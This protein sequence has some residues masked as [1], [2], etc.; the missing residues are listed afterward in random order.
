MMQEVE[1]SRFNLRLQIFI[2]QEVEYSR[3]NNRLQNL[4]CQEVEYSRFNLRLQNL[5][6]QE[7]EYSRFSFRL[8]NLICQEVEYSWF[9]LLL[10]ILICQEA[11]SIENTCTQQSCVSC[12][13]ALE[14]GAERCDMLPKI[15]SACFILVS[16]GYKGRGFHKQQEMETKIY[17]RWTQACDF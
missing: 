8:Q 16:N 10:Q 15:S 1:Y 7:V 12:A 3:F 14:G 13:P 11:Q 6:S 17:S 5:I 2:Y 4:I 9:N